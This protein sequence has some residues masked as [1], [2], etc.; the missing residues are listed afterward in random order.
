M[1]F[2][3]TVPVLLILIFMAT[4][5][6]HAQVTLYRDTDYR[7]LSES[8]RGDFRDLRSSR[9]GSDQASSVRVERGCVARL[10]RDVEYRG[11]YTEARGDLPDLRGS[12]VGNDQ[13]SSLQIRCDGDWGVG[14]GSSGGGVTVYRSTNYGGQSETLSRDVSDMGRTG[15]GNDRVRSVRVPDGCR[16]ELFED[17]NYRG[18]SV[19]LFKD[20][21]D[22]N[23]TRIGNDRVSSIR[24]C[25]LYTSDAADDEYNV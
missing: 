8:F 20:L 24:V 7:G 3:Q 1:R 13:A 4:A 18:E 25:L 23:R 19:V 9:I 17:A 11:P 21:N 12:S 5:S 10:F 6:V 2:R 22:L 16:A 15:I 14:S